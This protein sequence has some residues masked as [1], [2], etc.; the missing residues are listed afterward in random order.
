MSNENN[1][2]LEEKRRLAEKRDTFYTF[3]DMKR[4]HAGDA[5][6]GVFETV[7]DG[8][9]TQTGKTFKQYVFRLTEEFVYRNS[10]DVLPCGSLV[11]LSGA[12]FESRLEQFY[13][14]KGIDEWIM[15]YQ[16][17]KPTKSGYMAHNWNFSSIPHSAKAK[18]AQLSEEEP[19]MD[20]ILGT[21]AE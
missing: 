15:D 4:V 19:S 5:L 17:K 12:A 7:A 13:K 10:E 1:N 2:R 3:L 11:A 8:L 6:Y 14:G 9:N 16:G 20:N 21:A 18:V